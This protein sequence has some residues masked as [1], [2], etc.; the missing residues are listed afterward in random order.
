MQM[1]MLRKSALI[2]KSGNT[3]R[4]TTTGDTV[5]QVRV[6]ALV[7]SDK[8]NANAVVSGN[9]S[10]CNRDSFVLIDSGST[11]SFVTCAF[12]SRLSRPLESLPYLQCV[13]AL[14]GESVLCHLYIDFVTCVLG[15]LF[16]M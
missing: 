10:I 4:S 8:R 6:F 2:P 3:M 16:Y 11:P 5:R 7:P 1:H 9:I 13:S 12:A 14:S 15:M